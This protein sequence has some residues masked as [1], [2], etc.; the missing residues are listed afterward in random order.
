MDKLYKFSPIKNE[1]TLLDAAVYIIKEMRLLSGELLDASLPVK[2]VKI[3][4]HYPDEYDALKVILASLGESSLHTYTSDY[5]RLHKP[6]TVDGEE[7]TLLGIRIPDPYRL[8][9]GCGDFS[10]DVNYDEFVQKYVTNDDPTSFVR[11]AVGHILNMTELW[12]P[13][14]DVLGYVLAPDSEWSKDK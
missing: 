10:I 9:V 14:K 1:Q 4:A 6:I 2:S 7:V 12:H 8:Q 11:K 5:V 3:F 13:D